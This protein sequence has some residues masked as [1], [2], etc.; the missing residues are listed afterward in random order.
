[1]ATIQLTIDGI[2]TEAEDRTPILKIAERLGIKIPTL[3]HHPLIE[4]YGACR[5]CTVE[6]HN[7]NRVRMVTACN[8]PVTNGIEVLTDSPRV[9][10]DR[11]MILEWLL[12]RCGNVPV[13]NRLAEEYGIGEPRF[14]R[15]EDDCILCGLCVR[16][17]SDVVG[18]D[19][20]GFFNRGTTREVSTA[21][22]ETSDKCI[23]C[24]ACAYVC[25]TGAIQIQDDSA[26]IRDAL[27]LGPLTPIHIPFMQAVPHQPVIDRESCIHFKTGGCKV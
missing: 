4:P 5:I 27:P 22:G 21:Y 17:C 6:V 10:R 8:Y 11:K 7:R 1:M 2:R 14:G 19:V 23:A 24:G 12:S 18:A 3:C 26:L 16:V 13:L 15:G 9:R 25:P 20:L